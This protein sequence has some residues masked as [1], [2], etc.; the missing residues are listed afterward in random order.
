M[1]S[2]NT[3]P[4]YEGGRERGGEEEGR[5]GRREGGKK[6]GL[7]EE[8]KRRKNRDTTVEGKEGLRNGIR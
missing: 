5:E 2:L 7:N 1:R 8:E 6:K 4:S 3:Y